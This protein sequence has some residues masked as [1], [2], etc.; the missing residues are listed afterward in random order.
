MNRYLLIVLLLSAAPSFA[1]REKFQGF[2]MNLAAF[3][4][5]QSYCIDTHNLPADD[6]KIV[7]SFILQESKPN[8]LFTKLSWRRVNCGSVGLDASVRLE[9]PRDLSYI[10][11]SRDNITAALLVFRRGLPS[12]VY[13]TPAV[14]MI[15][16]PRPGN[17][18]GSAAKLVARPAEYA[19]LSSALRMLIHDWERR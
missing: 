7:E 5:I 10:P 15:G 9:L 3:R 14:T 13:E 6:A 18:D 1:Q 12:P 16:E 17:D 8:G 19:A 2:V 4:E 11:N